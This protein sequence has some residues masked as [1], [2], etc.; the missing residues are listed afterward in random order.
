MYQHF[1]VRGSQDGSVIVFLRVK[2][3]ERKKAPLAKK[4]KNE[5][6]KN[7]NY[8]GRSGRFG[9]SRVGRFLISSS[10]S[11]DFSAF[12]TIKGAAASSHGRQHLRRRPA[13]LTQDDREDVKSSGKTLNT[14]TRPSSKRVSVNHKVISFCYAPP[15]PKKNPKRKEKPAKA[16]FLLL[17]WR[18]LGVKFQ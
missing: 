14:I 13:V 3:K 10:F 5:K 11:L 8:N 15:V 12:L 6:S 2:E 16:V 4:N 18:S 17:L 1:G 9:V 7:N